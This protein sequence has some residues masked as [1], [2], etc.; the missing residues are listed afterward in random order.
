[1]VISHS[2]K[3]KN[4]VWMAGDLLPAE[5][6][7]IYVLSPTCQYGINVFEVVRCYF[8]KTNNQLLAFRLKD[9][10]ERLFQSAK[11]IRLNLKYTL[12]EVQDAFIKT[13]NANEYKEDI[14]VRI[15]FFINEFG[16]WNTECEG[17]LLISPIPRGRIYEDKDGIT[18]CVGSWERISDKCMSPRVKAGANYLNSRMAQLE[19]VNNGY[20]SALF[21]NR[22]GKLSEAPS[23]CIFMIKNGELITPPITASILESITR[24]T[25]IKIA[26]DNLGFSVCERNINRTELY[27]CDEMFL[28]GTTMEIAPVFSV[29]KIKIG[30]GQIGQMTKVIKG[31]YFDT[32]K[33]KNNLYKEWI[34][35]I[36]RS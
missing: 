36:N 24:D 13:I 2:S 18:C 32:V 1:M 22:E 25:I 23:S 6:A 31:K 14:T 4:I 27:S 16:S 34:F 33:G 29:D 21:L 19:A 11:T 15:V 8:D 28:C 3:N 10:L 17:E 7:K 20:D 9:H 30:N 26:R 35:P 5:D 12:S